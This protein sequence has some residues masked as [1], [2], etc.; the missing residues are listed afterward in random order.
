MARS[1][2]A[3]MSCEFY[4]EGVYYFSDHSFDEAAEYMG[5]IIV[6]PKTKEHF[7]EVTAEGFNPGDNHVTYAYKL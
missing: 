7:I 2:S 5:T 1:K 3:L 6:K 4:E